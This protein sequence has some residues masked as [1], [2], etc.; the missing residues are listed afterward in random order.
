MIEL[1]PA[2]EAAG[3]CTHERMTIL[4]RT[5]RAIITTNAVAV[6][7]TGRMSTVGVFSEH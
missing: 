2:A 3:T 4:S 1:A 6:A 7:S 5:V